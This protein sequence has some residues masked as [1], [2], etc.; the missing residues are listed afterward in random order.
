MHVV[1]HVHRDQVGGLAVSPCEE[2]HQALRLGEKSEPRY[3]H[4]LP[5]CSVRTVV[6]LEPTLLC[7][8]VFAA[9]CCGEQQEDPLLQ[10]R[11]GQRALQSLHGAGY[12]VRLVSSVTTPQTNPRSSRWIIFTAQVQ[13]FSPDS[14]KKNETNI[15]HTVA[16]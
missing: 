2:Q 1:L 14:M 9:V 7:V 8:F 16:S 13:S 12:R 5:L 3:S 6:Q 10:Q 4:A 11:A 15:D